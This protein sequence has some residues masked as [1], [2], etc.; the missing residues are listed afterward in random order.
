VER[1]LGSGGMEVLVEARH[2][3]LDVRVAIKFLKEEASPIPSVVERFAR[4]ARAMIRIKS[5]HVARVLDVGQ[6]AHGAPFMVMEYLEGRDLATLLAEF[7][8][9]P[10]PDAVDVVLQAA[11]PFAEA[12]ALGIFHRDLKPA[13]LF[14]TTRADGAPAVKV[15]DF[16]ISKLGATGRGNA[17]LSFMTTA[18]PLGSPLYMAPEQIASARDVDERANIWAVGAV[19]YELIS[20]HVPFD[21]DNINRLR[22]EILQEE[23]PALSDFARTVPPGLEVIVLRCLRKNP[24]ERYP[25]VAAL[26]ES[27]APFGGS[28]ALTSAKRILA[29]T[30]CPTNTSVGSSTSVLSLQTTELGSQVSRGPATTPARIL[31]PSAASPSLEAARQA[32]CGTPQETVAAWGTTGGRPTRRPRWLLLVAI[33]VALA[34]SATAWFAMR[35]GSGAPSASAS[36]LSNDRSAPSSISPA[37]AVPEP[38]AANPVVGSATASAV[39]SPGPSTSTPA[40]SLRVRSPRISPPAD[41][42]DGTDLFNTRKQ[43][44][45]LPWFLRASPALALFSCFSV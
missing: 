18:M 41:T 23:P 14:L 9:L 43:R 17:S 29:I 44:S 20:A 24:D 8:P 7:G 16:G 4:E 36:H 25:S 3:G 11:E 31:T 6:T 33:A 34:A 26:A 19:L 40:A 21:A 28:Q 32:R 22:Y 45:R 27:L 2:L 5:E 15:L 30:A 13:N 37:P 10:A 42:D 12:H 1:V 39:S 38:F 35:P